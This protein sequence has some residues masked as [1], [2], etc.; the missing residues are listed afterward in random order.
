MEIKEVKKSVL[1]SDGVHQ[2]K[3]IVM[4]PEGEIKGMFHVV[5]GMT[6]HIGRYHEF[7]MKIAGAGYLVFGYDHIGHGH[8][9][10][11]RSELGYFA[12]ENGWKILVDDVNV[13]AENVR[14]EYGRQL[15]YYLFGHSMGSFIV[16]LAAEKFDMQDKLIIMGTGGP[17]PSAAAGIM[18]LKILKK[19]RGAEY[20]SGKV[21]DLIFK[22]YNEGFDEND[23]HCW[24][25]SIEEERKKYKRDKLCDYIFTV[26]ALEDLVTLSHECNKKKWFSS[27][28][29]KKPILLLSGADDPVGN[30]GLG[31]KKVNDNLVK[32]GADVRFILYKD[33][34]H[35]ILNDVCR[36]KVTK[37]ILDFIG[38]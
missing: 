4:I 7:M 15:P 26:S 36:E 37:A 10:L 23:T 2:L 9:V 28:V 8:T 30:Y 13:F 12:P 5:H 3:G 16:R 29:A 35:E 22:A 18:L 38:N 11:N 25:S 14:N 34:R 21:N 19:Q 33:C 1:S 6:E 32:N 24:I 31:V 17:E 27:C 20:R